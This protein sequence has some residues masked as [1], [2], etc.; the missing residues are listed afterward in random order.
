MFQHNK[1]DYYSVNAEIAVLANQEQRIYET[2]LQLNQYD[3]QNF[4]QSNM[5]EEGQMYDSQL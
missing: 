4:E 3:P 2:Q 1:K 5:N